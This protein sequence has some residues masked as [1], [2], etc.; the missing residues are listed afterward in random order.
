MTGELYVPERAGPP[1]RA[2]GTVR[3]GGERLRI[4]GGESVFGEV[5]GLVHAPHDARVQIA[6]GAG[7]ALL[8]QERSASDDS[9]PA[10]APR[11]RS[12]AGGP[13]T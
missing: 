2:T 12:R 13:A 10:T 3:A 1:R 4:P 9:P 8:W 11:R 7:A 6:S 5:A